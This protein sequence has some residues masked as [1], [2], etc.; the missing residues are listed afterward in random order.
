MRETSLR[1]IH[2]ACVRMIRADYGGDDQS[3]T[4][5]GTQI[6]FRD[7]LGIRDFPAG[8]EMPFEAAWSPDGAVC[9]ARARI[10]ELLTL[11]ELASPIRILPTP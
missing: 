6:A 7:K 5:D 11:G 4:R 1:E 2:A 9:V 10:S 8:N 3:H